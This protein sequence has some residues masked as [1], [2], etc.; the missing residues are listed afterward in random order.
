[1]KLFPA[2]DKKRKT[3][4]LYLIL[5][6]LIWGAAGPIIKYTLEFVP[7][8]TFLFLRFLVASAIILPFM[9][10]EEKRHPVEKK[11]WLNLIL[12]S[13][14]GGSLT[15]G[16]VFWGFKYTTSIDGSLISSIAPVFIMLASVK[17][18]G[19]KITKNERMGSIIALAGTALIVFE[20]FFDGR[21]VAGKGGV[22][23]QL[24]GNFFM[25]LS[26]IAWAAYTVWS[27]KIL[28]HIPTKLGAFLHFLHLRSSTRQYSPFFITGLMSAIGLLTFAPLS[29]M[30]VAS[31]KGIRTDLNIKVIQKAVQDS[32]TLPSTPPEFIGPI[33]GILYMGIFSTL[34]A[35][36]LYEWAVKSLPVAETT[37]YS[38]LSPI[39]AV[40]LAYILLGEKVGLWFILGSIIIAFGVFLSERKN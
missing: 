9:I 3:A 33:L 29:F 30:E 4:I 24:L 1:M 17:L 31:I 21:D 19:E 18:L 14:L 2:S 7:P 40:P 32:Y 22:M 16:L 23:L 12:L 15:L 11:D 36:G 35:Y 27:K 38:Y 10:F 26:N 34:V 5:A 6:S 39:F 37:I 8:F 28:N 13:F 25:I 20:P